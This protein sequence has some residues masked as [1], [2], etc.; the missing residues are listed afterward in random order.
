MAH[1]KA[2]TQLP[3][4]VD[5]RGLKLQKTN[6]AT[7]PPTVSLHP[8]SDKLLTDKQQ[9]AVTSGKLPLMFKV[10]KGRL[11]SK[12]TSSPVAVATISPLLPMR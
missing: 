3:T 8:S 5:I 12:L 2:S 1:G 9:V 6:P 7:E 10:T 11:V 4:A